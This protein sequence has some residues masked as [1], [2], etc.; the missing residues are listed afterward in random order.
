MPLTHQLTNFTPLNG[1]NFKSWKEELE[2]WLGVNEL[3]QALRE[4]DPVA[5]TTE[6]DNDDTLATRIAKYE[7]TLGK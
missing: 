6:G 4:D 1:T 3:D 7:E 5:P 2:I